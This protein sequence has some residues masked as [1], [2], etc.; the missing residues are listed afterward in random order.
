MNRRFLF[1][2]ARVTVLLIVVLFVLGPLTIALFGGF[3]TNGEDI[4]VV[5]YAAEV[6]LQDAFNSSPIHL[7]YPAS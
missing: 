1:N 3:K 2:L 4:A 6:V 5:T 7:I